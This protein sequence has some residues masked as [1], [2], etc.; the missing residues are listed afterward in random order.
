MDP[1]LHIQVDVEGL[2]RAPTHGPIL[3]SNALPLHYQ[4]IRQD[5]QEYSAPQLSRANHLLEVKPHLLPQPHPIACM[6]DLHQC[7]KSKYY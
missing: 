1:C 7:K 2:R 6:L 4:V 3:Q 5:M